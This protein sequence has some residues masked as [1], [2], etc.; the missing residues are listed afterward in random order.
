MV[1]EGSTSLQS[2]GCKVVRFGCARFGLMTSSTYVSNI[3]LGFSTEFSTFAQALQ[4]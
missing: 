4:Y 1:S 3:R 2:S